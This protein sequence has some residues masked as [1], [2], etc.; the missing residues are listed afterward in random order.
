M[1]ALTTLTNTHV[2]E[3]TNV[4][5]IKVW[6]DENNQDG[7]RPTS[8]TVTLSNGQTVTLNDQNNW[9]ATIE[10]LPVYANG[11]AIQYTWTEAELPEGQP[12]QRQWRLCRRI[13]GYQDRLE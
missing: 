3:T 6:N 7:K 12:G 13:A 4:T 9:T 10:N 2:P 5:V 8:L 11:E 1:D